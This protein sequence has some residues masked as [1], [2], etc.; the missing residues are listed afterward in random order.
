MTIIW[1]LTFVNMNPWALEK[2]KPMNM[3]Y[4]PIMKS[5]LKKT[6]TKKLLGVTTDEDLTSTNIWKMY[7]RVLAESLMHYRECLLFLAINRKSLCQIL[8]LVDNSIIG[9]LFGCLVLLSLTE[10]STSYMRS[11]YDYVIMIT[12]RA[13]TNL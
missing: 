11:L 1:S 6:T 12:P 2:E 4:L 10:K 3:R 9:F 8:L 13:M 5:D 7:A